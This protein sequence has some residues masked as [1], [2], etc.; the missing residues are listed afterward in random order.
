MDTEVD[1]ALAILFLGLGE[2]R[3]AARDERTHVPVVVP[4]HPIEL[5]RHEG[6][7]DV[8]GPVEVA[9][10]LEEG[11][12]EPSMPG[13]ICR[14]GRRV[15][16]PVEVAGW[17]AERRK[18]RISDRRSIAIA[19]WAGPLGGLADASDRAPE[20]VEAFRLADR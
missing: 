2:R 3:E 6:E 5:V 9:Q 4:R 12:P 19:G 11:A 1:S 14:E 13:R 15:V 18:G 17:R 16:W 10:G 8:V 20:M 7:G